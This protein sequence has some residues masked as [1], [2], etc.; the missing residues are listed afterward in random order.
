MWRSSECRG[1]DR[2]CY[3]LFNRKLHS[4]AL[5]EVGRLGRDRRP[6]PASPR[7]PVRYHT[8]QRN[9]SGIKG[10]IQSG[11]IR[12]AIFGTVELVGTMCSPR[13]LG[14]EG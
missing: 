12:A 8:G 5:R 11:T 1:K 7:V 2:R 6:G 9:G 14:S 13:Q 10:G 3:Y 4:N